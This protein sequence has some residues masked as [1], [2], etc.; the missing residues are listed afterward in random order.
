MVF[1]QMINRFRRR[2]LDATLFRYP[3]VGLPLAD[4]V[5]RLST[6]LH[7]KPPDAIVAHSLGCMATSLAVRETNWRG[8]VVLLAP[9]FAT[10][11]ATR[12][13]PAFLRWPFAPLIDHRAMTSAANYQPPDFAGC[14][15]K[16]I[17]GRFDFA[18]PMSC[19]HCE[20]EDDFCRVLHT[21]NT[22]L[23]S[24]RVASLCADWIASSG[25]GGD[26]IANDARIR[27]F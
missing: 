18:V 17:V 16:T 22:M 11:P 21:H 24:A 27:D 19:S 13:I 4:I 15:V 7:R 9:P 14:S 26:S 20:G 10:L 6:S 2:S 3:S 25:S 23:F 1:R 5:D 12:M 8:P